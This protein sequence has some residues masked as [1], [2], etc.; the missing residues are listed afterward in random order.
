MN[1]KLENIDEIG[2]VTVEQVEKALFNFFQNEAGPALKLKAGKMLL[3]HFDRKAR[4]V[5]GNTESES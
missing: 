1:E 5:A 4:T 3:E 2:A